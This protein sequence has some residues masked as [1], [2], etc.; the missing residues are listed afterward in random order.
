MIY[1]P[2]IGSIYHLYTTYI[3]PVVGLYATYH[4]LREPERAIELK[5]W[6]AMIWYLHLPTFLDM[7][8]FFHPHKPPKRAGFFLPIWK[9]QGILG[10]GWAKIFWKCPETRDFARRCLYPF[11]LFGY[12]LNLLVLMTNNL[13]GDIARA[14][15]SGLGRCSGF[16][17]YFHPYLGMIPILTNIFQMGWFNHQPANVSVNMLFNDLFW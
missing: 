16:M 8:Q 6:P 1:N 17:F 12:F 5:L 10:G 11:W 15:V 13:R 4:L 14:A 9:I 2:P 3:L 7:W